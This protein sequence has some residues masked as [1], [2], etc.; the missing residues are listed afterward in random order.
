M[1]TPHKYHRSS[2]H[3]W[4]L[5]P[6]AF[7]I[8]VSILFSCS[9]QKGCYGTR[10]MSGYSYIRNLETGRVT[11]L[12]KDGSICVY[13]EEPMSKKEAQEYLNSKY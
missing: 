8:I 12:N 13:H 9:P 2:I 3:F 4:I 7:A 5:F 11:V 6:I 10:G 1:R